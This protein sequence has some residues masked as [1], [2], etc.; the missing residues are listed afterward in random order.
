MIMWR[1][2]FFFILLKEKMSI[3]NKRLPQR[4]NLDFQI[5]CLYIDLPEVFFSF[6]ISL[7]ILIKAKSFTNDYAE[8][9]ALWTLQIY[10]LRKSAN[11]HHLLIIISK[12]LWYDLDIY[13]ESWHPWPAEHHENLRNDFAL[14]R[15]PDSWPGTYV[16]LWIQ[17]GAEKWKR[18][19]VKKVVSGPGMM[20][21]DQILSIIVISECFVRKSVITFWKK[22]WNT[23]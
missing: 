19:F 4:E 3:S 6:L 16:K 5:S 17:V 23:V 1:M 12:W 8:R 15:I 20:C 22:N 18:Q 2:T 14:T 10:M 11:L 21:L 7:S 9:F 13:A